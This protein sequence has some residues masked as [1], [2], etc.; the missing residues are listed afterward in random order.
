MQC[1]CFKSSRYIP[2]PLSRTRSKDCSLGVN[3]I[4]CSSFHSASANEL[5]LTL[6]L[7][8]DHW[9]V[10]SKFS[11]TSQHLQ[12]WMKKTFKDTGQLNICQCID[13]TYLSNLIASKAV[14]EEE[15][16]ECVVEVGTKADQAVR[17]VGV[18]QL[19]EGCQCD[20]Q[21]ITH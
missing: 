14:V 12:Q 11:L 13:A 7:E 1:Q 2:N 19:P 18:G 6:E 5:D 21:C 17:L 10:H 3:V 8:D 9:L 4:G 15:V 16:S 20:T